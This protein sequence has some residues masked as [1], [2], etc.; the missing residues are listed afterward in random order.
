MHA[1]GTLFRI[2][3]YAFCPLLMLAQTANTGAIAGSVSDP[4]G[5]PVAGVAAV[6]NSEATRE[7][8]DLTSDAEGNFSVPFLRPGNYDLTVRAPGFE[9]LILKS[10]QVQITEVSRLKIQLTIRGAKEQITVSAR[11]PLLQ[12]ENSAMNRIIHGTLKQRAADRID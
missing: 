11:P 3:V 9:P 6:I 5:A 4:S 1:T 10:V 12:T 8:R 7:E 2:S